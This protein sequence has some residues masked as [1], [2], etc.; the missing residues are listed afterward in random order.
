MTSQIFELAEGQ[1]VTQGFELPPGAGDAVR[2]VTGGTGRYA[3]A[4]GESIQTTKGFNPTEGVVAS[5]D[6]ELKGV[7]RR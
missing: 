7:R 2:S 1:I 3:N 5:I 4:R 6:F